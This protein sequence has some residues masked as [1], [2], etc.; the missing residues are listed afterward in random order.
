MANNGYDRLE[1]M[2]KKVT[3]MLIQQMEKGVT[4]NQMWASGFP[5]NFVT[6]KE[7]NG[8]NSFF[9]SVVCNIMGYNLPYFLTIK[10]A[11]DLGGSVIAGSKG[12]Q[13][14]WWKRIVD[15]E[16][17]K[18]IKMFPKF[19]VVFN[20]SQIKGIDFGQKEKKAIDPASTIGSAQMI[21]NKYNP[22]IVEIDN[23][24]CYYS[25]MNDHINMVPK[26]KWADIESYYAVMFHEMIHHTGHHTRL[27]RF[28]KE[29]KSAAFGSVEYSMEELV[30]E[31][32]ASCLCAEVGI[33][34]RTIKNNAAYLKNW[35]I[36]LKN[37]STLIYKASSRALKAVEFILGKKPGQIEEMPDI[38]SFVL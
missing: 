35:L 22:K 6:G 13:V 2:S 31:I 23:T 21:V 32:G 25:P 4:W 9:L 1:E 20:A 5:Q 33:L 30:A 38:E 11:N 27:N 8:I 10:Q 19:Y 15:E 34:D 36:P 3:E 18:V 17:N 14:V 28:E 12:Y 26:N 16:T 7:Y 29:N 24:S 37:D